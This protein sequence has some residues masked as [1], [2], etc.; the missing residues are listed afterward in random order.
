VS[1][2]DVN[3][4]QG[5]LGGKEGDPKIKYYKSQVKGEWE[6]ADIGRI[7]EKASEARTKDRPRLIQKAYDAMNYLANNQ[8]KAERGYSVTSGGQRKNESG[9]NRD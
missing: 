5:M 9:Q 2:L 3:F 8:R 7:M 6:K 4:E 1:K